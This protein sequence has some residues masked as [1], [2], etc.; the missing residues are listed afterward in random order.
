MSENPTPITPVHIEEYEKLL[1]NLQC[2]LNLA[3]RGLRELKFEYMT[4]EC[5]KMLRKKEKWADDVRRGKVIP[6]NKHVWRLW[7]KNG[8]VKVCDICGKEEPNEER[9]V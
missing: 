1:H 2:I 9:K 6:C 5:Q 8:R 4:P 7:V 3:Q